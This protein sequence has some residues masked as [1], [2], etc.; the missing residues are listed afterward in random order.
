MSIYTYT[1]IH[2]HLHGEC[3]L[4]NFIVWPKALQGETFRKR[5]SL[6]LFVLFLFFLCLFLYIT[7]Y[8]MY[9]HILCSWVFWVEDCWG[10]VV[11][12]IFTR[13]RNYTSRSG[14]THCIQLKKR[15][16]IYH[17]MHEH[18]SHKFECDPGRLFMIHTYVFVFV[19]VCVTVCVSHFQIV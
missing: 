4:G 8:H 9:Y 6:A 14:V 15:Q 2:M 19:C 17:E 5:I 16:P 11:E 10:F 3:V 18:V 13:A 7:T 12:F 1:H